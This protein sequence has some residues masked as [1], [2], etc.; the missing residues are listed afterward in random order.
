[1]LIQSAA[2]C[3]GVVHAVANGMAQLG[4][5]HAAVQCKRRNDVHIINTGF[6]SHIKHCFNDPLTNVGALH[7]RKRQ[8]DIVKGDGELHAWE[9]LLGQRILL[10]GVQ[11]CMTNG[12]INVFDRG[13]WFWC[14][15]HATTT[16]G[17]LL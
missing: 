17:E 15:D 16:S 12:T 9:Q 1:M 6:G 7:L 4:F 14:V 3:K 11:Q 13:Q 2:R 5:G 10:D 8:T